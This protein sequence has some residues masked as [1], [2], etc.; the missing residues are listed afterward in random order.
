MLIGSTISRLPAVITP[1]ALPGLPEKKR[2]LP[3]DVHHHRAILP[4]W[5]PPVCCAPHRPEYKEVGVRTPGDARVASDTV[6]NDPVAPVK[7]GRSL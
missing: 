5:K 3:F 1:P 4:F 2:Q 7:T 6:K